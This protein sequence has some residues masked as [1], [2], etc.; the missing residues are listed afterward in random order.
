VRAE[1]VRVLDVDVPIVMDAGFAR[2]T[3]DSLLR[4]ARTLDQSVSFFLPD[5]HFGLEAGDRVSLP[6]H[7][8]LWQITRLDS[9]GSR[10][11]VRRV[12]AR[13]AENHGRTFPKSVVTPPISPPPIIWAPKPNIICLDMPGFGGAPRHG[14][15]V[16]AEL[17]PF[18]RAAI[19]QGEE[20]VIT[21][22]AVL[23]GRID[24][25]FDVG[26]IGLFDRAAAFEFTLRGGALSVA[27]ELG[28]DITFTG[29]AARRAADPLTLSY[30]ARHLRP[31]SPVHAVAERRDDRLYLSWIRRSRDSRS[32]S[33]AG[34]DVPLGEDAPFA[35][36]QTTQAE[37]LRIAQGAAAY[38]YGA[39]LEVLL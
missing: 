1:T 31:L 13:A 37:K 3:A 11:A 28:T 26:P 32:D 7:A 14:P 36:L 22:Q 35:V 8:G 10:G 19:S 34:L 23:A 27:A 4:R 2:L 17:S 33:W 18:S 38:G 12:T 25:A 29:I 15:L 5:S 24:T 39:V 30:H 6:Q 21:S 20:T 9:T 16:G